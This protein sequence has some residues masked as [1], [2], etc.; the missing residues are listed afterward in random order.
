MSLGDSFPQMTYK[1]KLIPIKT[2]KYAFNNLKILLI[3][4]EALCKKKKRDFYLS[5]YKTYIKKLKTDKSEVLV[6]SQ[7]SWYPPKVGGK[8]DSTGQQTMSMETDFE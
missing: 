8:T 5:I 7:T 2:S 1:L 6:F 3:L 4:K